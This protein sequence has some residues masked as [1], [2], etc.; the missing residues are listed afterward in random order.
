MARFEVP[1]WFYCAAFAAGTGWLQTQERLPAVGWIW[2]WPLA[3]SVLLLPRA[4]QHALDLTRQGAILLLVAALGFAYAAWRAE[5]RLAERLPAQA[6]GADV[7]LAGRVSGLPQVTPWGQVFDFD[8]APGQAPGAPGLRRVRLSWYA[9]RGVEPVPRPF[10][11]GQAWRLAA[12]LKQ[13]HGQLNFTGFDYEAWLLQHAIGASGYVRAQPA[14]QLLAQEAAGFS[15]VLDATRARIRDHILQV[16]GQ[17]PYAGVIAALAVGDQQAIPTW[18]WRDFNRT[19]VTHL[20]SISGLHVT[21]LAGLAAALA[22][23]TWRRVPYLALR[24]PAH[25]AAAVVGFAAAL[26]YSLLAGFQIPAQRTLFMLAAVA[27]GLLLARRPSAFSLLGLALLTV[28]V[29]DPWATLAAGFWLSF[30]AVAA[31]LWVGEG[32]IGRL[33]TLGGWALAQAAVT[34]ALAPA[35][36]LL[37][38]QVSLVSPLANALAIPLVSWIITPLALLGGLA[39]GWQA[40]LVWAQ[41]LMAGLGGLLHALA[42]WPMLVR[43]QP[44]WA[45]LLLAL[46][47]VAWMLLPRGMPARWLGGLMFL[48][49]LW[50]PEEHL[51]QGHFDATVLDVGQGT[52]VLLQTARHRLLYDSGPSYGESDAGERV[53]LPALRAAG[54]LRLDG[55]VLTHNDNDHIGGAASLLREAD[56]GWLLTSVPL[57]AET[58]WPVPRRLPCVRGQ[59]WHWDGVDFDVLNPPPQAYHEARADNAMS[60]VLKISSGSQALLLTGDAERPTE[61]EMAAEVPR[62]LSSSV[63]MA[64][65]HGSATSTVPAFLAAVRPSVV[66]FSAGYRN[67]YGHPHWRVLGDVRRAGATIYR[68]DRD[69]ALRLRFDPQTVAVASAAERRRRYWQ[70]GR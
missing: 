24:W 18:Q 38:Q 58:A 20:M 33:G 3:A 5:L 39:A 65:H 66:I 10:R 26:G 23:W 51:A 1:F 13:P 70:P 46:A 67:R 6:E 11:A 40:P 49:L 16:L 57:T 27:G 19:G 28:C 25:N 34:L 61:A 50:P 62:R 2:A 8:L 55:L 63:L 48:P 43:P 36:L 68:T 17:A 7:M 35:L 32:R 4:R 21:L 31:L 45:A 30:G 15:A 41:E 37:F 47:G 22:G 14:P 64:G 9:P 53:V 12:R 69:G 56:A 29:F 54:E 44:G 42:G 59:H 52:A 60:C